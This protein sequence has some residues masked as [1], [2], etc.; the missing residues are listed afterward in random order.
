MIFLFSIL[1]LSCHVW[2]WICILKKSES[3]LFCHF[4]SQD[5]PCLKHAVHI[6]LPILDI[7]C[8][9]HVFILSGAR[10]NQS[11]QKI[12][13]DPFPQRRKYL[14]PPPLDSLSR[15]SATRW[16]DHTAVTRSNKSDSYVMTR[17]VSGS[18]SMASALMP[19]IP[20]VTNATSISPSDRP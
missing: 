9:K 19:R 20:M 8:R 12:W 18:V 4:V 13:Y 11:L 1:A 5:F 6:L 17:D 15:H 16:Q 14:F 10:D 2:L 7:V 3:I